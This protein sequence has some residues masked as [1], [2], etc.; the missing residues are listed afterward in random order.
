MTSVIRSLQSL[1]KPLPTMLEIASPVAGS[2]TAAPKL[3]C[4]IIVPAF[5]ESKSVGRL[6]RRLHRVVPECDVLVIDDGSTDDTVRCL[7]AE[8]RVVSLP[9]NLGIGGAMQT[10]YRYAALHGYDIAVQ[11]DG[12]GQHRPGGVRALIDALHKN[13]ADIVVGSRFLAPRNFATSPMRLTGI[14]LLSIWI[15]MLSGLKVTDCTSGFRAVNQ[16]VI[17]AY[18]HWYPEDYP[19]PEV[20]LLLHRSNFKVIEIPT[21]MRRRMYGKSSIS[22]A[23]GIFYVLKVGVCLLMDTVRQPWPR[24][25]ID[26]S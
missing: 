9:F 23:S 12:D 2:S 6:V 19:E 18:A 26:A 21:R 24:G 22:L 16:R 7:P 8:A 17:R 13:N 25:K 10:G 5:N 14:R 20:V 11:V 4:L 1:A 15:R 3:K